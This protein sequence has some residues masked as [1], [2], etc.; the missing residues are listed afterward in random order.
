MWDGAGFDLFESKLRPPVRRPA[1]VS[2]RA[3]LDRLSDAEAV[4]VVSVVAPPGYGKTTFVAQWADRTRRQAAWLSLDARDNDPEILLTYVAAALHCVE[5]IS[6]YLFRT[7]TPGSFSSAVTATLR[8]ARAIASMSQ[9]VVLVLDQVEALENPE[10]LD[11]IAELSVNL[12]QGAQLVLASRR[13]APVSRGRT[14]RGVMDLGAVDL[15]VDRAEGRA[16]LHGAGVD[17]DEDELQGLLECTEGWPVGLYLAALSLNAGGSGPGAGIA[18]SGDDLLMADYL[19]AEVLSRLSADAVAFLTRTSVLERLSGALCD[20]VLET[21]GSAARL[22]S[23]ERSNLL[24]VPLGSRGEWYRYHHLFA[25]LLRTELVRR[26]PDLVPELHRRAAAWLEA[27][28]APELA[29]SHAQQADDTDRVVRLVLQLAQP[30]W[31][32]GRLDTVLRWMEWIEEHGLVPQAPEVAVH[33]ALIFALVGHALDAERWADA[34]EKAM[35]WGTTPDGST[36][37]SYLAYMRALLCRDGIAV[38]RR[39]AEAAWSGLHPASAYR[40]TMLHSQALADV[41]EGDATRGDAMLEAA[42]TQAIEVGALPFAAMI[43]AGRGVIAAD[44][45]EW[46]ASAAFASE[47]LEIVANG[48]YDGYW[49]SALVYAHAAR[50]AA[51]AGDDVAGRDLCARTARLRGLLTYALPVVS[52]QALLQLAHAYAGLDE[53][54]GARE[55]TRQVRAI[56]RRRPELGNV[57]VA[58]GELEAALDEASQHPPGAAALTTAELRLLPLLPTHLTFPEIGERLHISR[59]TVKTQAIS[60]Y[61]KLAVSSRSAAIARMRELGLIDETQFIPSG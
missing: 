56:L 30:T 55:V 43:L 60:I 6:P 44:Q 5:P 37:E 10:C 18:F 3:L 28:E 48:D 22:E 39:D 61:Q 20:A 9:P 42:H 35:V 4:P 41:L 29:L 24:L 25:D 13:V 8:L 14:R 38:M 1:I 16:L 45:N 27:H 17:V 26:E 15:V 54:A 46:A 33:G 59:H 31:A 12:P 53:T 51:H 47:A 52:A 32:S 34:A 7:R 11:L 2:R 58:V 57:P 50:V 36:V 19:H 21:K 49:T 40:P 23:L